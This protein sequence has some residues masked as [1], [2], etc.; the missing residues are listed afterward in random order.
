MS[1]PV[2][3]KKFISW[4]LEVC[5]TLTIGSHPVTFGVLK[6]LV[7]SSVSFKIKNKLCKYYTPASW[8]HRWSKSLTITSIMAVLSRSQDWLWP[9]WFKKHRCGQSVSSCCNKPCHS[10][11]KYWLENPISSWNETSSLPTT[12][13]LTTKSTLHHI[14]NEVLIALSTA[15]WTASCNVKFHNITVLH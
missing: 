1:H 4:V 13:Y 10:T 8:W 3:F 6:H 11:V 2:T 15:T 12:F 5:L 9:T 14:V 7:I